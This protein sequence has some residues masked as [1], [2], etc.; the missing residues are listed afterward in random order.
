M[1]VLLLVDSDARYVCILKQQEKYGCAVNI[2]G[3][4][5]DVFS[6]DFLFIP[7]HGKKK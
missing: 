6:T 3:F 2:W 4:F 7:N 1:S 5:V